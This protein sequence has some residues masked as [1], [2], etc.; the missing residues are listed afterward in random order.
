MSNF[1]SSVQ[2]IGCFT[3]K[4]LFDSAVAKKN[5]NIGNVDVTLDISNLTGEYYI[6]TIFYGYATKVVLGE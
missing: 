5:F 4:N 1:D 6:A 2:M 3:S